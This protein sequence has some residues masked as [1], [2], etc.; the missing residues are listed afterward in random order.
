ME[1]NG[2]GDPT[3]A[4]NYSMPG[5]LQRRSPRANA[6]RGW[7]S[8]CMEDSGSFLVSRRSCGTA[9]GTRRCGWSTA[10]QRRGEAERRGGSG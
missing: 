10:E 4:S 5:Y 2:A 9:L 1:V 3:P 7:P 6:V 8:A